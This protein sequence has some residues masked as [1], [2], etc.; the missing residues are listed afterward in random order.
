MSKIARKLKKR[1]IKTFGRGTYNGILRGYIAIRPY[2]NNK[3][4]KT[5]RTQ[6]LMG[7][8]PLKTWFHV[9]QVNPYITFPNIN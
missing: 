9:N 5:I 4:V 6:K 7:E 3:G 1:V 2:C 8:E